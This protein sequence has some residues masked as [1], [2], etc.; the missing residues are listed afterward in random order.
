[1][2]W[3]KRIPAA[4]GQG[5]RECNYE[6]TRERVVFIIMLMAGIFPALT[7]AVAAV[8]A[9]NR[10]GKALSWKFCLHAAA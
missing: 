8:A 6:R 10:R 9:D 1:M 7:L 5:E 3:C 4:N 2:N